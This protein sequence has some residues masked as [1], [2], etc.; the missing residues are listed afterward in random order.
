[1]NPPITGFT[2]PTSAIGC[3]APTLRDIISADV[4][5][6]YTKKRK[7]LH[8]DGPLRRRPWSRPEETALIARLLE[9]V[10]PLNPLRNHSATRQAPMPLVFQN[11]DLEALKL[12]DGQREGIEELRQ[13][14]LAELGGTNQ[15]QRSGI[16]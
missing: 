8:L 15:T 14:F 7:E 9:T 11:L 4:D 16:L 5:T 13:T 12:Q 1:L 10:P 3:P 6:L 2:L